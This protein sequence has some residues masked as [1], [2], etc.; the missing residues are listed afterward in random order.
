MEATFN[1][2][3][4]VQSKRQDHINWPEYFMSIAFLAAKRS[5]DPTTQVGACIVN[6]ENKL[7]GIGYNGFPKGCDDDLFPWSKD[8]KDPM[9]NKHL[10]VCHAETNAILNKNCSDLKGCIIYVGLF[11]CNECAKVIIQSGIREVVYFSDKHKEK[12][13]TKASK[14]MFDA[15][16]VK[17]M[18]FIPRQSR[19]VIDFDFETDVTEE[20]SGIS[21]EIKK[22]NIE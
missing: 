15:A 7:V 13:H 4:Q 9:K 19:I 20:D 3:N 11:P 8:P 22:L 18:H 21:Y 10:F 1:N 14:M 6:K 16:G 17:Y 2:D 12:S 5:K